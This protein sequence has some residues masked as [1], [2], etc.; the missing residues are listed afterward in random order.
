MEKAVLYLH[1]KG[2]STQEAERFAPLFPHC[3]VMGFDYAARTP[4]QARQ[5]FPPYMDALQSRYEAL[6]LIA[7]SLGAYLAMSASCEAYFKQA[8]FIS[9]IVDMAR[10]I[11]DMMAGCGVTE[12]EL[13]R[14]REIETP[15]GQTLS[16]DYLTYARKTPIRWSVPTHI[17]YGE[18]D[19]LTS[20]ETISAFAKRTGAALEVMPGG[21]HWFHTDAQMSYLDHWLRRNL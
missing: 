3:Q 7:N 1:G 9:P 18:R 11:E 16:W 13:Q 2:G 4:W 15:F 20:L 10:L 19:S 21:E 14:R 17:L 12:A 8:F 5:E 6:T